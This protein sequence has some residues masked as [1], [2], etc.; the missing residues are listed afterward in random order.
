MGIYATAACRC[1]R[2]AHERDLKEE[3]LVSDKECSLIVQLFVFMCCCKNENLCCS[4]LVGQVLATV[5]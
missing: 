2:D 4:S 1:S 3:R 5:E